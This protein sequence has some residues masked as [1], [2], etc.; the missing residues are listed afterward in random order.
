[1]F[2]HPVGIAAIGYFRLGDVSVGYTWRAGCTSV[3]Q[4]M[5]DAKALV[6]LT[7]AEPETCHLF[8]KNPIER[9]RSAWVAQPVRQYPDSIRRP[10]MEEYTNGV[11]DDVP[12]WRSPHSDPQLWQHRNIKNLITWRL[13]GSTHVLGVPLPHLNL[14]EEQ[15]P[16]AVHR[17]D[18]LK[19]YYA[20]D[21]K[22]WEVSPPCCEAPRE[23]GC[24]E[25]AEESCV[26]IM[27]P[28]RTL[29]GC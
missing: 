24:H 15:K 8:L 3:I 29:Y 7:G 19:E 5:Y 26:D 4:A 17:L 20:D 1:M 11:L 27:C 22:A 25:G 18:E 12:G 28:R 2:N 9:F 14:T 13:E 6:L 21:I 16:V 10:D 23:C